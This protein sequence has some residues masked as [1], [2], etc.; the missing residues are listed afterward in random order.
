MLGQ[1]GYADRVTAEAIRL[2]E[3]L[4][5]DMTI[6][7][8]PPIL[9]GGCDDPGTVRSPYD[10]G[11]WLKSLPNYPLSDAAAV[12]ISH[13]RGETG[14]VQG[15]LNL[16]LSLPI[17]L[18]SR[19]KKTLLSVSAPVNSLRAWGLCRWMLKPNSSFP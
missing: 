13:L 7:P 1:A 15:A 14:P 18:Q 8:A 16:R 2:S 11:N 6:V 12:A 10:V 4:G 5:G 17:S 9:W 3:G 19:I